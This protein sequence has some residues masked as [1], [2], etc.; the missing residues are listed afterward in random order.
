ML[1]NKKRM[2]RKTQRN[3][4]IL[5]ASSYSKQ[6]VLNPESVTKIDGIGVPVYIS[7]FGFGRDNGDRRGP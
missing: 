4:V 2:A 3:M 6:L 7:R 5:K 1:N